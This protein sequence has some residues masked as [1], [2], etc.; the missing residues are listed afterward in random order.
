MPELVQFK[1]GVPETVF[2][3]FLAPLL[4]AGHQELK[5]TLDIERQERRDEMAGLR[6]ELAALR[7]THS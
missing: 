1:D 5:R 6:A 3:Q 2:Y 7:A 4:L